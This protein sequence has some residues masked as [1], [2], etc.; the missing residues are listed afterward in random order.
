[1]EEKKDQLM[2][3]EGDAILRIGAVQQ[4]YEKAYEKKS[5]CR[6]IEVAAWRKTKNPQFIFLFL[7]FFQEL[8]TDK[9][10]SFRDFIFYHIG[11]LHLFR[12]F[13]LIT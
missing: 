8:H 13:L 6:G 3:A 11:L 7:S 5:D 1:L 12:M 4:E 9:V 10:I 2:V